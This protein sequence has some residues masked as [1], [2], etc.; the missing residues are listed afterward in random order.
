MSGIVRS[1]NSEAEIVARI[2]VAP[3]PDRGAALSAGRF[4]LAAYINV[5]VYRAFH[6]WLGRGDALGEHW[7]Q[8]DAGDRKGALEKIP[9]H[10]VDELLV[11]GSPDECRARIQRYIDNGVDCP[12]LA[13]M[14][15]GD[16]DLAEAIRGLAPTAT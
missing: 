16:V 12:A 11:H 4:V 6:E 2:F 7:E 1:E 10:V 5:P 13:V 14:P 3:T 8:W 15:F 9:E